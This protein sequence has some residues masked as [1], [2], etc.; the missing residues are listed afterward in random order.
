MSNQDFL[1]EIGLEEMP[2][3]FVTG[4]MYQLKEKVSDWLNEQR[5][6]F[7]EVQAFSTP[8]RLAVVVT[9]LADRQGDVVEEARGPAKKIA[10]AED[11]SWTKAAQGFARGQGVDPDQLFVKEVKGTEYLFAKKEI[12]GKETK[13]LLSQ[14]ESLITG[15]NF[16]KNMKWGTQKLRYVRPIHWIIALY[17]AE[18]IPFSI[19]DV[20]TGNMTRG[21]RFLGNEKVIEEPGQ[22]KEAL[23]SEFVIADPQ[24]RKEAVRKQIKMIEEEKGWK[25]PV[26]EELLEEVNN[27]IEYPTALYGSFDEDFLAIP[28]EVLITSMREHQ[29]YFSVE[30]QE[31]KLLPHFVTVRNGNDEHLENV[32]KGNEKVLRARLSDSAFFYKE[33][34]KKKPDQC[35]EQLDNIVYHEDLGSIGDKVSRVE[36]LTSALGN[37]INLSDT[38][39]SQA[40]RAAHLAKFDLVT[41]MVDEFPELQG[42]MGEKYA[43]LAG[44]EKEVAAAVNEHYSPRFAGDSVPKSIQGALVGIADKIDTIVGCFGIG[45]IP[46]GSQDPYGLRRQAAGVVQTAVEFRLD[47][48]LEEIIQLSL[49]TA[50][51]AGLLKMDR[52]VTAKEVLEFFGLRIKNLLTERG[53]RYDIVDAVLPGQYGK[54]DVLLSKAE[55]LNKKADEDEFKQT[56]E[57][58]SRITNIAKKAQHFENS[59]EEDLFESEE[60]KTLYTAYQK[61]KVTLPGLLKEGRIEEAYEQLSSLEET[62]NNYFDNVMVMTENETV[63]ENR[64]TQMNHLSEEIKK[65][66][67]FQHIVFP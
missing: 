34:Q 55:F 30:N 53:V 45:L 67:S 61:L 39:V 18:V 40:V 65:F 14:M 51:Q 21:H 1:L 37:G 59:I 48:N 6:E 66:A 23:L 54:L 63:K 11:G 7:S 17:G 64:L 47:L 58:L 46:T 41:H 4:A 57:A 50:E 35:V 2:A 42:F 44:E 56:V 8:R 22:Y 60:E 19:T 5:L 33:D 28:D 27:L 12:A 9:G 20:Q 24:E 16:P 62:I 49:T 10:V 15:M 26:K 38:V 3:R 36:K 13:E 43:L 29:R 52:K 25:I 31:G 32:Q